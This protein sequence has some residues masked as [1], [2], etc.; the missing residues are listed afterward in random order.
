MPDG[1]SVKDEARRVSSK[2]PSGAGEVRAD[3]EGG[4]GWYAFLARTGLIAKGLSY[5]LVGCLAI[6]V[7]V[8]SGGKATSR[9]GALQTLAQET[10]G[11]IFL[12]V[13]AFGFAAYAV[14]RFVQAFAEREDA[15][16]GEAKGTA[17]K[18]GKRAGY[19]GRGLIYASLTA[20]T[21]KI[22]LGSGTQSQNAKTKST[23]A[24]ILDWPGGRWIVGI[25]GAALIGAGLWNAYRGLKRK[26]EDKWRTGEMSEVARK[27]G[28]RAGLIGHLARGVVFA[29]IGVFVIKAAVEYD[30]QEAI[31]LDGAL[32][33]LA[34]S[35]YGPFL[36]GVTAA[37][38]IAY[39]LFCLVDARYRDV[40]ANSGGSSDERRGASGGR[41]EPVGAASG[42]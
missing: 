20:S 36:L 12:I 18:W 38:L 19:I 27:W 32:Q 1:T 2:A 16:E 15:D 30:A 7:A 34:G 6:Q 9:T 3:A 17:K 40:S 41:S 11:K 42:S 24:T 5:G 10:L 29:L 31:G 25:A 13:L 23:T 4:R 22:L 37:G 33:K 26:F 8:G 14:W 39:G 28:S 35:S 21:V